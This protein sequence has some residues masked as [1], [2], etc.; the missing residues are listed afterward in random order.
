MSH[1]GVDSDLTRKPPVRYGTILQV[2]VVM[3]VLAFLAQAILGSNPIMNR[4]HSTGKCVAIEVEGQYYDCNEPR[5]EGKTLESVSIKPG[6]TLVDL[7]QRQ[8]RLK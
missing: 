4:D 7:Q 5:F 6:T 1:P 2:A 3:A 8:G